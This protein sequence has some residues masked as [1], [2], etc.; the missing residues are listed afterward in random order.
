[1]LKGSMVGLRPLQSEDAWVLLKWFND[2]KVTKE[3]CLHEWPQDVSLEQEIQEVQVR[4]S[5][6]DARIFVVW[7]LERDCPIGLAEL[8]QIDP[9]NANARFH[10]MIGEMDFKD[11]AF[12]RM[13]SGCCS[14]WPS[15]I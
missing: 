10:V 2:P 15:I 3:L 4:I 1:M 11:E 5:R 12:V 13:P 6:L 7:A 9:R 14:R 8:I